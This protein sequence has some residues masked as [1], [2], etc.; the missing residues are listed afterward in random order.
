MVTHNF[1]VPLVRQTLFGALISAWSCHFGT[2]SV[3][4][5]DLHV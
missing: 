4:L 2:V 5:Y 3:V 1:Y